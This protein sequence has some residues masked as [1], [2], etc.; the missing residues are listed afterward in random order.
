MQCEKCGDRIEV[1]MVYTYK[2]KRVCDD[3]YIDLMIGVPDVDISKL[4]PEIRCGFQEVMKRWHRV[5][6]NRHHFR[7][8]QSGTEISKRGLS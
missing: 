4:S 2:D 8:P 6:P 7:Y 3:C 1:D 5:R